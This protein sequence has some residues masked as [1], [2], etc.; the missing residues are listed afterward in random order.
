MQPHTD[1]KNAIDERSTERMSFRTKPCIK[2]AIDKAAALSGV[3]ASAF[4]MHAAYKAAIRT[5][6][7]HEHTMLEPVDHQAFF[8]ALDR[9]PAPTDKL[10]SA[11]SR[12]KATIEHR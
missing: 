9:P 12:N 8:E 4:T 10:R 6:A 1:A 7:A 5:I 3:N 2:D 11:F